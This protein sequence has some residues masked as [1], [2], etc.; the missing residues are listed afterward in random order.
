[1]TR[2]AGLFRTSL[3][4]SN[5]IV[6]PSRRYP[7]RSWALSLEYRDRD[8][9]APVDPRYWSL[10]RTLE[11]TVSLGIETIG[12][13]RQG[14]L[15]LA[16]RKGSAAF[17][18]EGDPA[19]DGSY[20]WARFTVAESRQ[21]ASWNAAL[22]VALGSAFR[23]VPLERQ[24]DIAEESR[25]EAT[26]FFY[27]NDRGPLRETDH[28]LVPGGGGLRAYAGRAVLGQR[29]VAGTLELAND[30][31]PLFAFAD[32]GRVEAEGVGESDLPE[33][34]PLVGKSL[35]DVGIGFRYGALELAF[36]FWVSHPDGDEDPWRF[37][38][39]FSIGPVSL[40]S[41]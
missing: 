32:G 11:G 38:W 20:E 40:P 21:V 24:L 31:Y 17:R 18:E 30:A 28:F 16:F 19:P 25:M 2:D 13:R 35:A 6:A 15:H 9:L 23:R 36:P 22:R 8:E 5:T 7:H 29:L 39:L 26:S 27:A 14:G 10:G 33:L 34:H 3:G 1:V 37:R 4:A 41:P 12:P